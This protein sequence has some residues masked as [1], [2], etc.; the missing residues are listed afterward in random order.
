MHEASYRKFYLL[1][2]DNVKTVQILPVIF[3]LLISQYKRIFA[4]TYLRNVI[5]DRIYHSFAYF[6][7]L[8][9]DCLE[10]ATERLNHFS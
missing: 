8:G 2:I 7:Q 10:L 1:P 5:I 6:T 4:P 3:H 9:H